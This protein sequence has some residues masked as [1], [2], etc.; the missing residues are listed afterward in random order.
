MHTVSGGGGGCWSK[1]ESPL[2]NNVSLSPVIG[3]VIPAAAS[4]IPLPAINIFCCCCRILQSH[5][6]LV[7]KFQVDH[8]QLLAGP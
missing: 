1:G 4:R 5:F 8:K 6:N 7:N 3:P 2:H